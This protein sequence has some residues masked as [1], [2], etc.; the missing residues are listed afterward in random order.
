MIQVIRF[1][2]IGLVTVILLF[3]IHDVRAGENADTRDFLL[4]GSGLGLAVGLE[5]I[6]KDRLLAVSPM[7]SVPNTMDM[8][9][10][11]KLKWSD[12]KRGQA[13]VWSD[14]LLYGIS[15]SSLLWGPLAAE[16]RNQSALV[17]M[18][19]FGVNS[20]LT[21][22]F[23]IAIGRER[24]YHHFETR[25]S[26][27]PRDYASFFSGHSSIA[28]SQAVT[29]A[30]ILSDDYDEYKSLI[31]TALL[32]TAGLTSYLRVAGDMHYFSD[33]VVGACVGSLIAWTITN[34]EYDK[35]EDSEGGSLNSVAQRSRNNRDFLFTFKIPL[36]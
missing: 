24:P 33:I 4:A 22:V 25:E 3:P 36:G 29:N 5:L 9:I 16:N 18:Q 20:I 17:N 19:V 6:V 32:S 35:F 34:L 7:T 27:G 1:P 23:K 14:R 13:E 12:S 15:M 11:T 2:L 8:N 10:R 26:E 31:W 30:M 21:N 28:F